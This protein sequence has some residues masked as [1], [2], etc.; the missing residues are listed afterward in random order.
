MPLEMQGMSMTLH[1]LSTDVAVQVL[2]AAGLKLLTLVPFL[3]GQAVFTAL[4]VQL[5]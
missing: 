2:P 4:A 3:M 5:I 1:E